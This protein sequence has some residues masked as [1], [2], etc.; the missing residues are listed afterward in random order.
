MKL[1]GFL[2]AIRVATLPML[3]PN[4]LQ[5][6]TSHKRHHSFL[7]SAIL[8]TASIS[9]TLPSAFAAP[10]SA[11][12]VGEFAG[13][14]LAVREAKGFSKRLT[15][16]EALDVQEKFVRKLQPTLGK[17]VGYKVGL[18][19]R[20]AQ[21]RF[22][23]EFPVRGV[24]LEKMLLPNDSLVPTNFG[25][26][27]L[28]EADLIVVVKDKAINDAESILEVAEHIKEVVA[29]IEL[30][31]SFIA[32]NP[33][34]DGAMLTAGNVGARLGVLGRR[35]PVQGTADFVKALAEMTVTIT[36]NTGAVLG[37]E[38]SN[39]ILDHPLNALLWLMEELRESGTKLRPGDLISLG[40]I[41]AI[42]VPHGKSITVKYEGLP[43]GPIDVSVRFQ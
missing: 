35:V 43:G 5:T 27:P 3:R 11:K 2:H 23:V 19:S 4:N 38:R 34:P 22:G 36:D 25:V 31:D 20:E 40:S 1:I 37:R 30:P 16:R 41:K 18:V 29:F 13:D 42:T 33:P 8:L 10:P 32:T 24:L 17:Q 26:R 6:R 28:F 14:Y 7:M 15:M 9:T 12:A 21:Q 39:V